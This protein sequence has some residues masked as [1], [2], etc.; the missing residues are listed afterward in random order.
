LPYLDEDESHNLEA[1]FP[2]L[3]A[4]DPGVVHCRDAIGTTPLIDVDMSFV[5]SPALMKMLIDAK[6]DVDAYLDHDVP[7]SLLIRFDK[8]DASDAE[9]KRQCLQLLLDAGADP[10]LY[11]GA[12]G[13]TLLMQLFATGED[14]YMVRYK[15][16]ES[17]FLGAPAILGDIINA[18]AFRIARDHDSSHVDREIEE[19]IV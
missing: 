3:L 2:V 8:S 16:P 14:D 15:Y 7:F 12:G 10:T 9:A 18:V 13:E 19:A 1:V 4:R 11:T 6:A 5:T 17:G